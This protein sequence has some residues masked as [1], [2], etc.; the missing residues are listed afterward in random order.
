M[1]YADSHH[2]VRETITLVIIRLKKMI[3][4]SIGELKILVL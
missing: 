2:D 4:L 3:V 1:K